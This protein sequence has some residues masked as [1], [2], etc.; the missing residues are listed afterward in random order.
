MST[1]FFRLLIRVTIFRA[2][3]SGDKGFTSYAGGTS[4]Q[5]RSEEEMV[6]NL[7]FCLK[8]RDTCGLLSWGEESLSA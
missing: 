6:S 7:L 4:G 1:H 8:S 5:E 2:A 3:A